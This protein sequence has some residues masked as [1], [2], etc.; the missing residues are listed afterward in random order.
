METKN[1]N[2]EEFMARLK[3]ALT[4]IKA[5]REMEASQPK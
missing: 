4:K 5:K 1:I 2:K 3:E